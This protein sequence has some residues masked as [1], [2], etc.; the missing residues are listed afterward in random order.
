MKLGL[1]PPL[2]ENKAAKEWFKSCNHVGPQENLAEM[3]HQNNDTPSFSKNAS[4]LPVAN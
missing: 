4:G 3:R 2:M 1:N